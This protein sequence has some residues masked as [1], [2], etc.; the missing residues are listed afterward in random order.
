MALILNLK[1]D[2]NPPNV[3]EDIYT[4]RVYIHILT[5]LMLFLGDYV[6]TIIASFDKENEQNL[7]N[8]LWH[9]VCLISYT[10]NQ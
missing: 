8:H 4:N 2:T 3:S 9:L 1:Q 7:D 10:I 6:G 5:P